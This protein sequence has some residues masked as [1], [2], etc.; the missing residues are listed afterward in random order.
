MLEKSEPP[1]AVLRAWPGVSI[2]KA[3]HLAAELKWS[4]ALG[5][6]AGLELLALQ[7][8]SW[9]AGIQVLTLLPAGWLLWLAVRSLYEGGTGAQD[10]R[11]RKAWK[12]LRVPILG[13][14]VLSG[15]LFLTTQLP[16][17]SRWFGQV[18]SDLSDVMLV[19][20]VGFAFWSMETRRLGLRRSPDE[21]VRPGG[22]DGGADEQREPNDGGVVLRDVAAVHDAEDD[23]KCN[24]HDDGEED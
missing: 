18:S 23:E 16:R 5:L 14:L 24:H 15:F 10:I 19:S 2:N 20:G 13:V 9:T 7:F 17:S 8:G 21:Y 4:I 3:C 6:V 11:D 12:A 1:G 22:A